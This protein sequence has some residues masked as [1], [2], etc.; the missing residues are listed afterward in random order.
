MIIEFKVWVHRTQSAIINVLVFSLEAKSKFA[1]P[2]RSLFEVRDSYCFHL[3]TEMRFKMHVSL[4]QGNFKNLHSIHHIPFS[5]LSDCESLCWDEASQPQ[6][7]LGQLPSWVITHEVCPPTGFGNESWVKKFCCVK[8]PNSWGS[9]LLNENFANPEPSV[10]HLEFS[11][12]AHL[13][14]LEPW[15]TRKLSRRLSGN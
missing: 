13:S 5:C 11:V 14:H 12:K 3:G 2:S 1:F 6:S 4:L 8:S 7:C 9:L 10:Y 15:K